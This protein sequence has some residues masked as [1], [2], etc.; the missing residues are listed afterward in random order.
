[1]NDR[2][3]WRERVRDI[4]CADGTTRW[5]DD[6]ENINSMITILSS[7]RCLEY[8]H[9]IPYKEVRPPLKKYSLEYDTKLHL[10]VRLQFWRYMMYLLL[11]L[12][13]GLLWPGAVL[14]AIVPSIGLIDLF[15][16]KYLLSLGLC[17]KNLKKLNKNV[18]INAIL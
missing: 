10:I 7:R 15:I 18:N 1:M 8:S 12:L 16:K 3:E 11:P 4:C 17:E 6:D 5:W 9:C 2:D 14:P 13:S